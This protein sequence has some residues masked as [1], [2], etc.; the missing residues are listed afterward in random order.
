MIQRIYVFFFFFLSAQ[1]KH[2]VFVGVA[3]SFDQANLY[4]EN[5]FPNGRLATIKDEASE[6]ALKAFLIHVYGSK[7]GSGKYRYSATVW[8]LLQVRFKCVS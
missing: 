6:T 1:T 8:L 2:Y 3:G 5:E 4:C 7:L